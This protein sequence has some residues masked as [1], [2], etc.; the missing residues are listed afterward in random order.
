MKI[1]STKLKRKMR[2]RQKL[3]RISPGLPRLSFYKSNQHI[4]A[5]IIDSK[6]GNI[7]AAYHSSMLKKKL[8]KQKIAALVGAKIAKLCL[9]KNITKVKFDRGGYIYHGCVKS[10]AEA[11]RAAGLNF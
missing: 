10:F 2:V 6:T 9:K 5:Q 1:T 4:F 7:K 11:A 8:P 3:K